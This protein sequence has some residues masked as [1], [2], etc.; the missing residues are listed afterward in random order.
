METQANGQLNE[1]VKRGQQAGQELKKNASKVSTEAVNR[2][3]DVATQVQ[4]VVKTKFNQFSE[5]AIAYRTDA[6]GAIRKK[7]ADTPG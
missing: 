6:E 1:T 4:D 2:F 3:E 7:S 5:N